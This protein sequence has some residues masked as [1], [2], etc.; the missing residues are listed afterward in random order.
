[1]KD[2]Y[3][4]GDKVHDVFFNRYGIVTRVFSKSLVVKYKSSTTR[5]TQI[6]MPEF[7]ED[8]KVIKP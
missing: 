2:Y 4:V 6:K 8:L 7:L 5:Y 1:M 3:K